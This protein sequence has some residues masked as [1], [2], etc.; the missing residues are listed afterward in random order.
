MVGWEKKILENGTMRPMRLEPKHFTL[1]VAG[2]CH[3]I[4]S[5]VSAALV[6]WFTCGCTGSS[7][8]Y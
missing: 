1:L 5:V 8:L 4:L 3:S 7:D 6:I 2:S